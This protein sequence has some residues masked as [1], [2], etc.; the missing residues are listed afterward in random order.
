[1]APT[2][3]WFHLC[4]GVVLYRR[5]RIFRKIQPLLNGSASIAVV[6]DIGRKRTTRRSTMIK[7]LGYLQLIHTWHKRKMAAV[8]AVLPRGRTAAPFIAASVFASSCNDGELSLT[9]DLA[10]DPPADVTIQEVVTPLLGLEF[11]KSDNSIVTLEFSDAE[12]TDLLDF[13]TGAPLRMFSDEELPEGTY[14]GVRLLFEQSDTNEPFVLD[15]TGAQVTMALTE[16]DYASIDLVVDED[17]NSDESLTLTLDLRQSL[18][19]N[20]DED[21]YELSPVLRSVPTESAG[22]IRGVIT[23]DCGSDVAV[24]AF[25][26]EEV[27]PDD[28]DLSGVEPFATAPVDPFDLSY[29]L[30]FLP[31]G[32]YTLAVVCNASDEDPITDEEL[33][34]ESV[35]TVALEEGEALQQDL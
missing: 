2:A 15:G 32:D 9:A 6:G 16:G 29:V 13:T 8:A 11:R 4:P 21:Q 34:F 18:S 14:N 23:T 3:C 17:D 35:T 24:Y 10:V 12:V 31:E 7:L 5:W 20:D 30:V 26:G 1:M 33:D 25:S 27:E 19:F 28:I 22:E